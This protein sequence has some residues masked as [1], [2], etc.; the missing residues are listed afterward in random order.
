VY[1]TELVLYNFVQFK[2]EV[3]MKRS[4]KA[5]LLVAL[6]ALGGGGNGAENEREG[7]IVFPPEYVSNWESYYNYYLD[8]NNDGFADINMTL[9]ERSSQQVMKLL[10]RYL[11]QGVKIVFEDKG[12]K[13][14]EE[15]GSGRMIGF[16]TLDGQFVRLD[17][18]FSEDIIR[19][20]FPMLWQKIQA[21]QRA[22]R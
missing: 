1:K 15:F 10:S 17:Q 8:T 22:S 7:E 6:M 4:N 11:Q 20:Y 18:M 21:E 2:R 5:K 12:L 14:R 16:I 13:P 3:K 9:G 19:Q